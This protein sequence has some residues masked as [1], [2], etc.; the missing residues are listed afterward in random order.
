[1][2]NT[3][4][5]HSAPYNKT[6]LQT[7]KIRYQGGAESS[8]K[9]GC[10]ET[11]GGCSE[12]FPSLLPA[13][14]PRS[15]SSQNKNTTKQQA[16][17][18][19]EENMSSDRSTATREVQAD[20]LSTLKKTSYITNDTTRAHINSLHLD[21]FN[22]LK[23]ITKERKLKCERAIKARID[24]Q[25]IAPRKTQYQYHYRLFADYLEILQ[26]ELDRIL[27]IEDYM[28]D[29]E[30][31]IKF[32]YEHYLEYRFHPIKDRKPTPFV[33][34]VQNVVTTSIQQAFSPS[35]EFSSTRE[36]FAQIIRNFSP[37]SDISESE[38]EPETNTTQRKAWSTDDSSD[39]DSDSSW[40]E[41][42]IKTQQVWMLPVSETN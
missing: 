20:I 10:C 1:M 23:R 32:K 34:N 22:R 36:S 4:N 26:I 37:Y 6:C 14:H 38:S 25:Q 17:K 12:I 28:A 9:G 7:I 18:Q 16:T 8:D 35:P 15:Q 13:H 41:H 30:D 19:Q 31:M 3:K 2:V 21:D 39:S 24:G 5:D 33:Q 42:D 11:N 27:K 40:G 29:Q